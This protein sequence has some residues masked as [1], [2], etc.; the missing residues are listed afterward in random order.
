MRAIVTVIGRD[1]KGII[2]DVCQQLSQLGVNVL[3]ISQTILRE[4]FTM[5]M[6]VDTTDCTLPFRELVSEMEKRGEETG[7]SVR[8]QREDIFDAMHRI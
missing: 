7:L 6:I 1:R 8:V 2:A 3:D 4:Y 5:I